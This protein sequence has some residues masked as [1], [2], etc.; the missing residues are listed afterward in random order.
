M[1]RWLFLAL[2]LLFGVHTAHAE[3][4]VAQGELGSDTRWSGTVRIT[5]DV[6]VPMGARL[7]I[8]AGTQILIAKDATGLPVSLSCP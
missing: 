8:A 1:G 3:E 2:V 5:G 6:T 4:T 7:T